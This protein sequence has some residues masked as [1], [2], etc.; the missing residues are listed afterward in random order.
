MSFL[1]DLKT[2]Y[3]V[4]FRPIRGQDHAS[5]MESFYGAQAAGYDAFRERLLKGRAEMYQAIDPPQGA[6]WIDMGGGTG[7]N[8]EQLGD[9][10]HSLSRCVIVDIS[11]SMLDVAKQRIQRRGWQ[12]VETLQADVT[13][14]PVVSEPVDVVTF[15]YSLTMIPDWPLALETAKSMLKPGGTIGVV[16]FYISRK[17]PSEAQRRHRWFTRSFWPIWFA[18]NNVYPTPDHLAYLQSHFD[19]I[20]LHESSA[21]VPY[22]PLLKSPYYWFIGRKRE[23]E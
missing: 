23:G 9:R 8:L 13:A 6:V 3:Q 5:R 17:H 22:V 10:I 11:Q 19:Q 20:S 16:D 4:T 14:G 15:S 2:L 7:A 18:V 21:G 1:A 12:H